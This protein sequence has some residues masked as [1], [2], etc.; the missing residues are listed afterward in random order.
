MKKTIFFTLFIAAITTLSS[1][2]CHTCTCNNVGGYSGKICQKDYNSTTDYN[3]A[4]KAVENA[5]CSCK[6][7]M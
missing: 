5:G 6:L 4:V 2:K 3:N 1:C 7:S